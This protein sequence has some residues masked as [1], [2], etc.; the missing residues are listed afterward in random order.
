MLIAARLLA[1]RSVGSDTYFLPLVP[2]LLR[3]V[4]GYQNSP[5]E[6]PHR[7]LV[8]ESSRP[9]EGEH[10][11]QGANGTLAQQIERNPADEPFCVKPPRQKV[12][13]LKTI[14]Q[15]WVTDGRLS[16]HILAAHLHQQPRIGH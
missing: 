15:H 1:A 8:R 3:L 6:K 10:P 9:L 14:L 16:A 4:V 7:Q 12:L 13:F 11:S 5:G 2:N